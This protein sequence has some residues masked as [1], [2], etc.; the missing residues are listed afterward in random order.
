[1]KV[2]DLVF[3]RHE[4]RTTNTIGIITRIGTNDYG[5]TLYFVRYPCGD[6][7]ETWHHHTKVEAICK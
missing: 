4:G 6:S 1:M 2:G 5:V 3:Y 7:Y